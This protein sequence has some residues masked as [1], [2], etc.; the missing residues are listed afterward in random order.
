MTRPMN[1]LRVRLNGVEVHAVVT[2]SGPWVTLS[3]ALGASHAMWA[4]QVQALAGSHTVL[5]YDIRGHGESAAPPGP[6]SLEQLADDA[7]ALL[8]HLGVQR[9]HWVGLSLGGMIGQVL[10]LRHPQML[11]RVVLADTN[12]QVPPAGQAMWNERAAL[13]RREGMGALVEGTLERWFTPGFAA[14]DPLTRQRVGAQIA[15]TPVEGYAAC[16]SAICGLATLDHLA[17][18]SHPALVV[19]GEQDMATPV[20]I[21][22][23]IAQAWPGAELV[24]LPGA[25]H[26]SN[27]EQ[28]EAFNRELLRFLGQ[29]R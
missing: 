17:S 2:G 28:P 21:S 14:R 23:Q 10:A 15:A 24:V 16:C 11:G 3:H 27:L 13:A 1:P 26:L 5:S 20:A 19:V 8:M 9:T 7:H 18:L 25:A 6:Y 22:R 12:A 4:P 29:T